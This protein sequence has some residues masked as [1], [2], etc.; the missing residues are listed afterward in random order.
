MKIALMVEGA[1]EEAFL[2]VFREF[3][4]SRLAGRM[5]AIVPFTYRSLPQ[6]KR[7]RGEV[8]RLLSGKS[9]ADAVVALTDVYTGTVP[10]RFE[11][12]A[13]A[14][15]KLRDWAG[16]NPAF[17]A[18]AAQYDFEAWLIPYW[19][20]IQRIAGSKLALPSKHPEHINH[21][22]LASYHIREAFRTGTKRKAYVKKRDAL[23]I[24]RG[25]DLMASIT[26]CPELKAFVNTFL[27][28][29][30]GELIA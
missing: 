11:N 14:R 5:P 28:L 19:N 13:D 10:P 17:Y 1:T 30:G 7:F 4:S 2:S 16:H 24:L 27:E 9:P 3:L 20:S 26:A 22:R 8:E 23:R 15:S 12:A 18:H 6:G 21:S 25:Q 29:C